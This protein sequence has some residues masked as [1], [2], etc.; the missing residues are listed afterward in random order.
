MQEGLEQ[1]LFKWLLQISGKEVEDE[2]RLFEKLGRFSIRMDDHM[3]D[4][5]EF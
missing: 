1:W 3:L 4:L 5:I 2:P